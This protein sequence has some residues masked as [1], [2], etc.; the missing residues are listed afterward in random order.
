MSPETACG[1]R[2]A[3]P[4]LLTRR[5]FAA[6]T[7]VMII[8]AVTAII[9]VIGCAATNAKPQELHA[10]SSPHTDPHT[11]AYLQENT[12]T[13][14]HATLHLYGTMSH[15]QTKNFS[16]RLTQAALHR[17]WHLYPAYHPG[18]ELQGITLWAEDLELAR[19]LLHNP[20]EAFRRMNSEPP[21][22][23][24]DT[25]QVTVE[26][27]PDTSTV[28]QVWTLTA[29]ISIFGA[30]LSLMACVAGGER[31]PPD[32]LDRRRTRYTPTPP[33]P[34]AALKCP[35]TRSPT[36]TRSSTARDPSSSPISCSARTPS[37]AA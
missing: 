8:S 23:S 13:P 33:A 36:T 29:V 1:R 14:A 5:M 37:S 4:A 27:R 28:H 32:P 25:V 2:P 10:S 6:C 18:S 22:R 31:S 21:A 16:E 17:Q 9:S 20:S 15:E 3:K 35:R 19:N 11:L 12:E 26:W 24:Q 30:A 7:A 34:A